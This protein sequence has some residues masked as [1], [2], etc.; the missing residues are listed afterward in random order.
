M[1]AGEGS[2]GAVEHSAPGQAWGP[3]AVGSCLL[4]WES[5]QGVAGADPYLLKFQACCEGKQVGKEGAGL[6]RVKGPCTPA[7]F[8]RPVC[9]CSCLLPL[10]LLPYT[11]SFRRL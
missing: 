6:L 8:E 2:R 5:L 1:V 4:L 9:E 3:L 10:L 11:A 7:F